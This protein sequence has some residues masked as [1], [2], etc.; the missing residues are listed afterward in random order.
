MNVY[1]V[2][3]GDTLWKIAQR[4][5][6]PVDALITANPQLSN[7]NVLNV[8]QQINVPAGGVMVGPG[9]AAVAAQGPPGAHQYIVK[10]GDTLWKIA[11]RAGLTVQALAA[12]NPQI[13][14]ANHIYPGQ[15]IWVPGPGGSA[16]LGGSPSGSVAWKEV[17]T[18]PKEK[19]TAPKPVAPQPP[20]PP[21]APP[22]HVDANF[23]F[24]NIK[25]EHQAPKMKPSPPSVTK[26]HVH[27]EEIVT[28]EI[29]QPIGEQI[30]CWDPACPPPEGP[31]FEGP[32]M[33]VPYATP[34]FVAGP[35][36]VGPSGYV[37]KHKIKESSSVWL[38]DSSWLRD[39]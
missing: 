9:S 21:A 25:E 35:G 31:V 11:Q 39:S 27:K 5:G 1:V 33:P 8:G 24:M 12:A 28:N 29:K 38:T 3:Q 15:A 23:Q 36:F 2:K 16:G 19:L 34:P 7:P 6:V 26:I 32:V 30:I 14:N 10:P 22:L 20:M 18:A 17:M 37:T 13:A 4:F